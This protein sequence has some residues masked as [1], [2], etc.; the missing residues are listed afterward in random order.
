MLIQRGRARGQV[1]RRV[2]CERCPCRYQ[3]EL[4]RDVSAVSAVPLVAFVFLAPFM[5]VSA[6]HPGLLFRRFTFWGKATL[7]ATAGTTNEGD[8]AAMRK[9]GRALKRHVEPVA[10]PQCGWYQRPMVAEVRR[11]ALA[12]TERV[13]VGL[14]VA[15][16]IGLVV[17][18]R[19]HLLP[20][21][22]AHLWAGAGPATAWWAVTAVAGTVAAAM[23]VARWLIAR[24]VDPNRGHPTPR[25]PYPGAPP[26]VTEAAWVAA[27]AA[28]TA[29]LS[30]PRQPPRPARIGAI[31]P[32]R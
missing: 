28:A 9:L 1:T 26:A 19:R 18:A 11:R 27:Q 31:V 10:C 12:W 30:A 6:R 24:T 7:G 4:S 23:L 29:R 3:Y 2:S 5:L 13:A 15:S 17:A 20:T 8:D 21:A 14:I 16:Q 25:P 32:P 22:A